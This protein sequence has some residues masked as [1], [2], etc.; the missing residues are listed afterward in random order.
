MKGS[1]RTPSLP[2]DRE[3]RGYWDT[4]SLAEH[5]ED[6]REGTIRFVRRPKQA[7]SIRLDPEDIAKVEA[8]AEAKGMSYTAL[9]R[10]WIKAHLAA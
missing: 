7:I 2:T 8:I 1:R 6:T 9:L 10:M 3:A 5:I 4:H